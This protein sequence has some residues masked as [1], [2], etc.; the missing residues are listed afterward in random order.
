MN[1][2]DQFY[3]DQGCNGTAY[4]TQIVAAVT[5][6]D[7]PVGELTVVFQYA[8]AEVPKLSGTVAM[9]Y[10]ARREAFVGVLP[11]VDYG[12]APS[13][14]GTFNITVQAKDPRGLTAAPVT[15]TVGLRSCYIIG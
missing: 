13:S 7:H 9:Q 3:G 2:V 4:Q 11:R 6:P 8:L 1:P 14:G 10:D 15:L 12:T 5:D